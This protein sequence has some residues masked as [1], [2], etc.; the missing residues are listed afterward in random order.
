MKIIAY[1]LFVLVIVCSCSDKNNDVQKVRLPEFKEIYASSKHVDVELLV[2][3]KIFIHDD[4]LI[5]FEQLPTDMFKVFSLYSLKYLYSFGNRGGGPE[6]FISISN[7]NIISVDGEYIEI[8]DMGKIKY[9]KLS[10]STACKIKETPIAISYLNSPVNRLKKLNDDNYY[11]DNIFEESQQE[12]FTCLNIGSR[13]QTYFSNYP[14]WEKNIKSPHDKYITYLKSTCY[15]SF[16]DKIAVFYFNFPVMKILDEKGKFIKEIYFENEECFPIY[17]Y[18][19]DN[20]IYFSEPLATN[21]FIYV[22]WIGK[23]KSSVGD[24]MENFKPEILVFNWNGD[25]LDRYRLDK[26]IITFTV[27]ESLGK[28]YC[29]SFLEPE[30]IYEYNLP[31]LNNNILPLTRMKNSLYSVDIIN[32]YELSQA[33]VE[34]GSH[35]IVEKDGYRINL[36]YFSQEKNE[37]GYRK[38]DLEAIEIGMYEP[39]NDTG[40]VNIKDILKIGNN[41]IIQRQQ[42]IIVNENKVFQIIYSCESLNPKGEPE[43]LY[44]CDH[45]FEKDDKIIKISVNSKNNNFSIFLPSIQKM[46][47]SFNILPV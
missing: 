7:N 5:V 30:I 17:E 27:S 33:S 2:P 21:D 8:Y 35:K 18:G 31:E 23:T 24:D 46:I 29:T 13:T 20:I 12:E 22:L 45:I 36:N 38:Y 37:R 9:L 43:I 4:K 40:N 28:I 11:F 44:T 34:D 39:I 41:C 42:E 3:G 15:N 25:V 16:N 19:N 10:D 6:E 47:S 26:P 32:G 1:V 14:K